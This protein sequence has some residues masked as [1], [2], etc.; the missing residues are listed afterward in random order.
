MQG[1]IFFSFFLFHFFF[2]VYVIVFKALRKYK[3]FFVFLFSQCQCPE[4]RDPFANKY[5][6]ISRGYIIQHAVHCL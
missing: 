5:R 2:L 4:T 3:R 6:S 1:I